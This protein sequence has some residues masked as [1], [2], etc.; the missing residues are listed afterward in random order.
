MNLGTSNWRVWENV[1]Q[2]HTHGQ[3]LR[4]SIRCIQPTK[5][6]ATYWSERATHLPQMRQCFER[7]GF[8]AWNRDYVT[9]TEQSETSSPCT[10]Y[11]RFVH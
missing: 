4:Q 9:Y 8:L 7:R 5:G 11:R 6:I 10:E 3:W 2:F 1:P